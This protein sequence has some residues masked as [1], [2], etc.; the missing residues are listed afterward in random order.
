MCDVGIRKFQTQIILTKNVFS[1]CSPGIKSE[2]MNE[3]ILEFLLYI[4]FNC[5]PLRCRYVY[6]QNVIE[7]VTLT[8]DN[9]GTI[10][11]LG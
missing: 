11:C 6:Q 7:M 2:L 3:E 1:F 5:F 10:H 4:N 8:D 9:L